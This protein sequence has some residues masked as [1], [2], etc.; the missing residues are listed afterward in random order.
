MVVNALD[1]ERLLKLPLETV[2]ALMAQ[3][4]AAQS[5]L[6][7]RLLSSE[8]KAEPEDKLLDLEEASRM[9][10]VKKDWIYSR[11][12]SLPFIVRL[13]RKLR[14]SRCGIEKYIKTQIAGGQ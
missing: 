9:L 14:Y 11:T 12:R 5:T 3:M 6:A 4:A 10:G 1:L 7:A 13:G 2:P 8:Q